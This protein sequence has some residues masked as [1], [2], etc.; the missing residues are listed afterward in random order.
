M[1]DTKKSI[2]RLYVFLIILFIQSIM[3]IVVFSMNNHKNLGWT[4]P[5]YFLQFII[6][7]LNVYE[8]V[9]TLKSSN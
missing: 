9:E 5:L 6:A 3:Y 4:I 2:F 8:I 1:E 7:Y